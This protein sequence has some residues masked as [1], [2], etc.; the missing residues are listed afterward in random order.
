MLKG[1]KQGTER[2]TSTQRMSD[3]H[4]TWDGEGLSEG[5]L[6]RLRPNGWERASYVKNGEQSI[7]VKGIPQTH[8]SRWERFDEF[9]AGRCSRCLVSKQRRYSWERGVGKAD[10]AGS[11]TPRWGVWILFFVKEEV[12]EMFLKQASDVVPSREWT[13]SGQ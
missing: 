4:E 8:S 5:A 7:Q 13:E 2:N 6:F 12:T 9:K 10:G 3:L 11:L 1:K